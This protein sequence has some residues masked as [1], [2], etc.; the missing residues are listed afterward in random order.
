[1]LERLQQAPAAGRRRYAELVRRDDVAHHLLLDL[2]DR[3]N[4][5]TDQL[6]RLETQLGAF[7]TRQEDVAARVLALT[8]GRCVDRIVEVEFGANLAA[9]AAMIAPHGWIA[10]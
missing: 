8:G 2:H 10:A 6:S 1:M 5:L 7:A 9:A 4:G 3:V